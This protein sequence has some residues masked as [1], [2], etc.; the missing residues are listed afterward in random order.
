M[1]RH[2]EHCLGSCAGSPRGLPRRCESRY[3]EG[4]PA[5]APAAHCSVPSCI[6]QKLLE[7]RWDNIQVC[8]AATNS[9]LPT[10]LDIG[11]SSE[12]VLRP[13]GDTQEKSRLASASS[14]KVACTPKGSQPASR[15][16]RFQHPTVAFHYSGHASQRSVQLIIPIDLYTGIVI[17]L[18]PH[19]ELEPAVLGLI[20]NLEGRLFSTC[21]GAPPFATVIG[22]IAFCI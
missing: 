6:Q 16:A 1:K 20:V 13:N 17:W 21:L 5:P 2:I 12:L 19:R 3:L 9:V 11:T 7:V 4:T 14:E 15:A 8:E 22:S 18:A 10:H